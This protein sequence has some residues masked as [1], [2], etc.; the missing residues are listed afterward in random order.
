MAKTYDLQQTNPSNLA[1]YWTSINP[2]LLKGEIGF[3]S[4]TL[5][6]KI[7]D[8]VTPWRELPY[9]TSSTNQLLQGE[10]ISIQNH[11]IGATLLYEEIT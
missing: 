1:S 11:Q 4:D 2:V 5:A 6:F 3:E 7:G 9:S 10:G 8:G